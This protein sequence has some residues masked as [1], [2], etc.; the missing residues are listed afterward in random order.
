VI[1]ICERQITPRPTPHP[2]EVLDDTATVE[3]ATARV[4]AASAEPLRVEMTMANERRALLVA[5]STSLEASSEE[6]VELERLLARDLAR[7]LPRIASQLEMLVLVSGS[8]KRAHNLIFVSA[9]AAALWLNGE[10]TDEEFEETW[11]RQSAP[12]SAQ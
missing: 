5:Y 2:S 10:L 9:R 11:V 8:G 7:L 4:R 3:E 6:F 1:R 12:R